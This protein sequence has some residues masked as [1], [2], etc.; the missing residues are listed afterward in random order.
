MKE[1]SEQDKKQIESLKEELGKAESPC[2]GEGK[3]SVPSKFSFL[4]TTN[5]NWIDLHKELENQNFPLSI[6]PYS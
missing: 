3:W 2:P 4:R 5:C 6:P 1:A